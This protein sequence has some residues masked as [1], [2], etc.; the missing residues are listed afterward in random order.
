VIVC[1]GGVG[2]HGVVH[3]LQVDEWV[4]VVARSSVVVSVVELFQVIPELVQVDPGGGCHFPGQDWL[5]L[6]AI[7]SR[8]Q[9]IDETGR[10]DGKVF[11]VLLTHFVVVAVAVIVAVV[12]AVVVVE[13]VCYDFFP[14]KMI[15]TFRCCCCLSRDV[16]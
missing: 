7:V 12:V 1:V 15:E 4:V 14:E 3:R 16:R 5:H 13:K 11:L 10:G 9:V 8:W 6:T 2:G